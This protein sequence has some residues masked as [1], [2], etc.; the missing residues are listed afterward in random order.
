MRIYKPGEIVEVVFPFEEKE[1]KKIRPALVI[2]DFGDSFLIIKITSKHKGRKWDI[3]LPK[4]NFNGLNVDSVIQIDK[5]IE[6]D[7]T[8]VSNIIPRGIIN[9]LQL[10][11]VKNKLKEYNAYQKKSTEQ[12]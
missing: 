10:A 12:K 11:I 7:K 3:E 4:D 9:Q 1:D 8:N 2:H 5:Y 6:L